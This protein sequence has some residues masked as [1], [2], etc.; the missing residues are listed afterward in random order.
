MEQDIVNKKWQEVKEKLKEHWGNIN[1][2]DIAQMDGSY[3]ELKVLLQI[4][5]GYQKFKAEK[6]IDHF[7]KINGWETP[8]SSN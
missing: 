2:N 5:Y 8:Q 1:D 3:Q 4:R 7:L 6:E